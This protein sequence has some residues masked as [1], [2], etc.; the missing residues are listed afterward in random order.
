[1]ATRDALREGLDLGLK[2]YVAKLAEVL[3][4]STGADDGELVE[5]FKSGLDKAIRRHAKAAAALDEMD[6]L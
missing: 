1:M 4:T 2:N 6:G 5:H 3:I